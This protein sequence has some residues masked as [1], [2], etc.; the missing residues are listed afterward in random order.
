MMRGTIDL[1]KGDPTRCPTLEFVNL[2]DKGMRIAREGKQIL[3]NPGETHELQ[4]GDVVAIISGVLINVKWVPLCC[5]VQPVMGKSPVSLEACA[6]LGLHVVHIPD[7]HVTHHVLP[8]YTAQPIVAA[9]LI[10]AC[11]FVKLEWL[12]EVIRLGTLPK[13]AD[14][15]HGIPL[16]H[17]FNLPPLNKYRP[18]YSPSLPTSQKEFRVWEPN[19]ERLKMFSALRFLFVDEKPRFGDY[20]EVIERG[21]GSFET[22]DVTGGK[23]KLH[24]TLTR[25]QA[26]EGK[27]QIVVGKEK[28]LTAAIGKEAWRELVEEVKSFGLHIVNPETIVE[29]VIELD[30]SLFDTPPA[31][32]VDV[33]EAG[34]STSLPDFIPNTH[35]EEPSVA[36]PEPEQRAGPP[37]RLVRRAT[38]RQASQG[39]SSQQVMKT[40]EPEEPAEVPRLRKGLTRRV[41]PGGVPLVIGLD[42]PSVILDSAPDL[43]GPP[44][45]PPPAPIVDLTAP[46]PMRSNRLKRR[47]GPGASDTLASQGIGFSLGLD[48]LT[49]EPPLKKFKALFD[50]SHPDNVGSG[51]FDDSAFDDFPPTTYGSSSQTQTQSQTQS[52][53]NRPG[54]AGAAANLSILREEEE[55]TQGSTLE[56]RG[57]K[58]TLDDVHED[59]EMDDADGD[60][61]SGPSL[62]KKRAVEDINAVDRVAS[63]PKPPSAR[64]ASKPPSTAAPKAKGGALPGKPD[65]DTKFLKAIASTKRGKKTED[66]FDRDF[67]KLKISKPELVHEEPEDEWAVLADFGDDTNVR[68]NFM[69][70]MEMQAYNR[71][72]REKNGETT[73]EWQGKPNFKKFKRASRF[74][75]EQKGEVIR[76]SRVEL[77]INEGNDY[78]MGAGYWKGGK[79]QAQTQGDFAPIQVKSEPSTQKSQ[80][81]QVINDSDDEEVVVVPR[82]GRAKAPSRSGSA[83]PTK[84]ASTRSKAST[85]SQPLFMDSDE[86][87]DEIQHINEDNE[88]APVDSDDDQT[89]R[90]TRTRGTQRTTR[91]TSKKPAPILVDDD[92]DDGAVFKGFKGKQTR[93]RT[94][95]SNGGW[96]IDSSQAVKYW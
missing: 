52:K 45:T 64:A 90:S 50:A 68:G 28:S 33:D 51:A 69:V 10:S 49:E 84:R 31:T 26:K 35:S 39:P 16:E 92:S 2:K 8:S 36:P 82:K 80:A 83:V 78:G 17:S 75:T 91:A 20:K 60:S 77:F 54:R 96:L 86:D 56:S 9:S 7:S 25:G 71:G 19:E 74:L 48:T 62:A 43:S 79:S 70:V 72:R 27:K 1:E 15:A 34:D 22:F 13:S 58:R 67:N 63:A 6:S 5:Y 18:T 23:S 89:L 93:R 40:P 88:S 30:M 29:V 3:V 94:Q 66:D 61:A 41:K 73:L 21:G 24:R 76:K 81:P 55:D 65:Q 95:G 44:S 38:S 53:A 4:D 42:D 32:D 85:K 12:A 37:K 57:T 59:V 46:T 87:D 11:Q 14:F 47:V